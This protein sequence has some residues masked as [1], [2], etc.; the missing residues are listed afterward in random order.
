MHAYN[1][2]SCHFVCDE[3]V[4]PVGP[5]KYSPLTLEI[6]NFMLLQI[7]ETSSHSYENPEYQKKETSPF[8]SLLCKMETFY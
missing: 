2:F 7:S 5:P 8:V 4:T 3:H 6:G 1:R